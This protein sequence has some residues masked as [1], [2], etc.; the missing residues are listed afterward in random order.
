VSRFL[1]GEIFTIF[2]TQHLKRNEK[3]DSGP[4]PCLMLGKSFRALEQANSRPMNS[5]GFYYGNFVTTA[6]MPQIVPTPCKTSRGYSPSVDRP[7]LSPGRWWGGES[8]RSSNTLFI[9][10]RLPISKRQPSHQRTGKGQAASPLGGFGALEQA[11]SRPM[12]SGGFY[13]GNSASSALM[14]QIVPTP[15][16]AGRGYSPSVDRP[17]LSPGRWWEG[18]SSRSSDMAIYPC[19]PPDQQKAIQPSED[20][21]RTGCKP[22]WGLWIPGTGK[23]TSYE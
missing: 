2:S 20:G 4:K 7:H 15:G 9:P 1:I 14:P 8:S 11:N 5:G 16:F 17:H 3:P 21:Q 22:A 13:Y 12:N 6:L 18:E 10:V 19:T 23:L